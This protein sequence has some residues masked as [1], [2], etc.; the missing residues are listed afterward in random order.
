MV[1]TGK[2]VREVARHFGFTHSAVVKWVK[3]AQRLH[4]NL[5]ILP[6]RSPRP[7]NHPSTLKPEVILKI[8]EYRKKR[9]QCAFI[10]HHLLEQDGYGVSLSSVKRVLKR[11]GISK[12]S[13]WKKWHQYGERPVPEKPGILIETD[14]IQEQRQKERIYVYTLIDVYSRYAFALPT[15]RANTHES[16]KFVERAR[17]IIPFPFQTLQ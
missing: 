10:I 3:R 6:T 8:L 13:R 2:S 16:L 7:H 9:N 14:T 15:E 5:H 1:E 11:H 4:H 17:N 12:Y